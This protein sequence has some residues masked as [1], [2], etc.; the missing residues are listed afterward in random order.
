LL[1]SGERLFLLTAIPRWRQK[2]TLGWR[3]NLG[4]TL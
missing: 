4:E 2:S 1:L 3:S